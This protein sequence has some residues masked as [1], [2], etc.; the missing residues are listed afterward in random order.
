M[1]DQEEG[2]CKKV[3]ETI[4]WLSTKEDKYEVL[5]KRAIPAQPYNKMKPCRPP[6]SGST[7]AQKLKRGSFEMDVVK[8]PLTAGGA[9]C[10]R[11]LAVYGFL[12]ETGAE[13]NVPMPKLLTTYR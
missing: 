1:V 12:R 8:K 9:A 4:Q 5:K 7:G 13:P 10:Q 6:N 11:T 3:H 2:G